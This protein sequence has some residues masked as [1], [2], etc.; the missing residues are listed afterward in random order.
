VRPILSAISLLDVREF[1]LRSSK[2]LLSILSKIK[3][4]ITKNVIILRGT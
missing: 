1:C 2:I 4:R 3:H